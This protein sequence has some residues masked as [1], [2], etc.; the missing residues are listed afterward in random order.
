M[1]IVLIGLATIAVVGPLLAMRPA[2]RTPA[3][4]L[5][6]REAGGSASRPQG[7]AQIA[8]AM[9]CEPLPVAAPVVASADGSRTVHVRFPD[10][11]PVA[12]LTIPRGAV[13]KPT[14]FTLSAPAGTERV[15]VEINARDEAGSVVT[16]FSGE[17]L[18]LDMHLRRGCT[19]RRPRSAQHSFYIFQLDPSDSSLTEPRGD[20]NDVGVMQA[21]PRV[22]AQLD[23]LSGYIIAQGAKPLP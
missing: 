3:T 13:S 19:P 9:R 11:N 10:S 18:G 1:R 21:T 22:R 4:S 20:W 6:A 12:I 5:P 2:G 15:L 16:D 14:T 7:R 8:E 17:P 23:H